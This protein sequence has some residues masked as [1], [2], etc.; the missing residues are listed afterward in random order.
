MR[1]S[2]IRI[3]EFN[4]N[5]NSLKDE[6]MILDIKNKT[7]QL[8]L[9]KIPSNIL[10]SGKKLS[11]SQINS[12]LT[13]QQK[14]ITSNLSS[15]LTQSQ[16]KN[17]T[18]APQTISMSSIK[19]TTTPMKSVYQ[20]LSN[21]STVQQNNRQ[22]FVKFWERNTPSKL[23]RTEMEERRKQE[24]LLKEKKEKE[25]LEEIARQKALEQEKKKKQNEEKHKKMIEF[26]EK[27][28]EEQ[29][30]KAREAEKKR[31]ESEKK[32]L[33]DQENLKREQ[34]KK[35]QEEIEETKR[36]R[37][38]LE[39]KSKENEKKKISIALKSNI[40]AS[41]TKK[42]MMIS[43]IKP[44]NSVSSTSNTNTDS[45]LSKKLTIQNQKFQQQEILNTFKNDQ[46]E[47]ECLN[48][49][50][51]LSKMNQPFVI[52]GISIT[53]NKENNENLNPNCDK[54][55][56]ETTY[57]LNSPK[58]PPMKEKK[59]ISEPT[60]SSYDVT[61]LQVPKLKDED[62]YDVSGLRSEDETDD[63]DEPSINLFRL[64]ILKI[65]YAS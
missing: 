13:N 9:Q 35:K 24:F 43:V 60:I 56:L 55:N 27:Q 37:E 33:E 17:R 26:K 58:K 12:A 53:S 25:R 47:H 3:S 36:K 20:S 32:Q 1:K 22:S 63:E 65:F 2:Q 59:F 6:E 29:E 42:Q 54:N 49:M 7:P 57:I 23:T 11:A 10:A 34:E 51:T 62:N 52:P 8:I 31:I 48:Q 28:K 15:H 5:A 18:L 41:A 45:I 21:L 30:A 40:M 14:S 46:Y 50:Q 38:E 44:H 61:P 16:L 64:L 19:S 4:A 39:A